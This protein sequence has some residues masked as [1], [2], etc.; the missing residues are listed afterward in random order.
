MVE[1]DDQL[2]VEGTKNQR[3]RKQTFNCFTGTFQIITQPSL[4]IR[5]ANNFIIKLLYRKE[6]WTIMGFI[7]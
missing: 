1:Q 4:R 5:I 2:E 3:S 7:L 6:K